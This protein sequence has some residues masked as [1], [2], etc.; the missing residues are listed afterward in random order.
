MDYSLLVKG[1]R[2]E[3]K[4]N[5]QFKKLTP[6]KRVLAIIALIPLIVSTFFSFI[7]YYVTLFFYKGIISPL[8]FLHKLVRTEGQEV[9]HATQAIIYWI[10]F[11]FIFFFYALNSLYAVMFYF[12]WFG[13][14][15]NTYL[16]TLGGVR[17]QPFMTD[18]KYEEVEL[19]SKNTDEEV[20]KFAQIIFIFAALVVGGIVLSL[21]HPIFLVVTGVGAIL[22]SIY[23]YIVCPVKLKIEVKE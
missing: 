16:V 14:M 20:N 13:L 2:N 23:V 7:S 18:A 21:L 11:P 10:A 22:W 19:V 15:L 4:K 1:L 8:D 17:W 3:A 9:K 5:V 12:S 6:T